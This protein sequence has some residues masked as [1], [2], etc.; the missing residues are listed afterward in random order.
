MSLSIINALV[1][2]ASGFIG[3]NLVQRLLSE[4]C[5]VET[6]SRSPLR[7]EVASNPNCIQRTVDVL[8]GAALPDPPSGGWGAVFQFAGESR[9]SRFVGQQ[10]L[11]TTVQLAGKV[12]NHV[13]T[14]SPGCRYFLNSSAY[15]YSPSEAPCEE[16]SPTEPSGPY[17]L[18][19]LLAED[20]TR[21]HSD[22]MHVT[23]VRPFNLIGAGLPDGL[24]ATDLLARLR[25]GT[26]PVQIPA[27]NSKRDMLDIR[28]AIQA[29]VALLGSDYETGTAFNFCSGAATPASEL[30]DAVLGVL[31][32]SREVRFEGEA[33]APLVGSHS[34]LKSVSGWAPQFG[35]ADIAKALATAP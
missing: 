4:G 17:G 34:R 11:R 20:V 12:A 15:V 31:G 33:G 2:G 30:A 27:P 9:P 16:D 14:T 18:A 28:D 26:G 10:H 7:E 32:E 13:A 25:A 23:I 35:L 6:W 22:S 29:Y 21:L 24:F 8:A 5:R 1:V 3:H 19:K